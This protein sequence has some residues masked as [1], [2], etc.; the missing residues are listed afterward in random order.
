MSFIGWHTVRVP[1]GLTPE[2]LK[3]VEDAAFAWLRGH[4]ATQVW[5]VKQS[6]DTYRIIETWPDRA[7][8]SKFIET[9]RVGVLYFKAFGGEMVEG[10]GGA[11]DIVASR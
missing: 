4:G 3:T 7:K 10:Q 2:I 11:G 9:A 1:G 5:L 8:H 6:E